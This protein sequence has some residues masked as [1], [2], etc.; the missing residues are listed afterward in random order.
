MLFVS[1]QDT[2]RQQKTNLRNLSIA[3]SAQTF[4]VA[5]AVDNVMLQA[6]RGYAG[7]RAAAP[8]ANSLADFGENS[9]AREYL[10]GIHLYDNDGRL[11]AS[12]VPAKP[13]APPRCRRPARSARRSTPSRDA[14][15]ITITDVDPV[16]GRGVINFTRPTRRRRRQAHRHH[17][18]AG[19]L[20]ALRAHL[21]PG[22]AGQGRLGDAVQPRRH[23]AG[24]R[25]EF[26]GRHRPARSPTRRCSRSTCRSATAAR[27]P[28]SARSTARPA[29][30]LRRGQ[31][32]S[33]GDHHRHGPRP[34]RWPPGTAG[35][36]R[37]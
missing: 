12:G 11:V 24:A 1:Y 17:R 27:S 3:F 30:R 7:R 29:V 32:L 20:G 8:A 23:D 22:R 34:T 14:L 19:R 35:C 21:Q 6:E 36:G 9:M 31:Q 4:S 5:Q 25:P 37:R 18:R 15:R 33:A 28:P 2:L 26:P 13:N 10:L 16:T